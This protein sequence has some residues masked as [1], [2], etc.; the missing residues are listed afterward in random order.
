M[1][2][3]GIN[4]NSDLKQ[5]IIPSQNSKGKCKK[6]KK[7]NTYPLLKEYETLGLIWYGLRLVQELVAGFLYLLFLSLLSCGLYQ[8]LHRL[9]EHNALLQKSGEHNFK[10]P[11]SIR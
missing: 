7:L 6:G 9:W 5:S 4:V 8:E 3:S 11:M 1:Y 2:L 10:S